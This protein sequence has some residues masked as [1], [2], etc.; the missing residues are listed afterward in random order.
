MHTPSPLASTSAGSLRLLANDDLP[1]ASDVFARAF[2]V[3]PVVS[4]LLPDDVARA[5]FARWMGEASIRAALPYASVWGVE[6]TG[7][8]AGLAVWHPPSVVP[9]SIGDTLALLRGVPA[10]LP[11]LLRMSPRFVLVAGLEPC[12]LRRL[13]H[14]QARARAEAGVGPAWHL[15]YLAVAPEHQ[16]NGYARLL[17][18][19]VLDRCDEDGTAAWLETTDP[20]NPARYE[21]FGFQTVRQVHHGRRLPGL[22]VMR[23]EPYGVGPLARVD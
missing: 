15:A 16:G 10:V 20:A 21:R 19:H 4:L 11:D 14:T 8:L 18:D 12:R 5:R 3:D 2:D 17:L 22:W 7:E 6:V 13:L 9:G 23:R 1:A